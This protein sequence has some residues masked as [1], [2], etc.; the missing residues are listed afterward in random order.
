LANLCE[1]LGDLPEALRL[2]GSII[3][4][5][6][7]TEVPYMNMGNYYLNR[8]D[9]STAVKYFEK[10]ALLDPE[11]Q[12]LFIDLGDYFKENGDL[13]KARYYYDKANNVKQ[14]NFSE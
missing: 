4:I 7:K 5:N 14:L 1:K 12:K 2:N 13:K 6:P 10:A 3:K 8:A 9:E 11:N